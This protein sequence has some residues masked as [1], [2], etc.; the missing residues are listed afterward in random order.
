MQWAA[1]FPDGT[2]GYAVWHI[3][4]AD[5]APALRRFLVDEGFIGPG[6]PI[7]S[8]TTY[9]TPAMHERLRVEYEVVPYVVH[10][11]QGE[12]MLIPAGRAH[13]VSLLYACTC[14]HYIHIGIW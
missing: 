4:S 12:S 1:D 2:A 11:R 14:T 9:V 7:H 3:Y 6:D 10:Q 5:A 8:Q 13:Q